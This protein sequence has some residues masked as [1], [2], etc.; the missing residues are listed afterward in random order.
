MFYIILKSRFVSARSKFFKMNLLQ[1][2]AKEKDGFSFGES[3]RYSKDS[4]VAVVPIL[5]KSL[6]RRNYLVLSETK[7]VQIKDTGQINK[8]ELVNNEKKPIYI[9]QGEIFSGKTQ[10]RTAIRSYVVMPG[11]S[12]RIEVRC[13]YASKGINIGETMT[14]GGF[15]TSSFDTTFNRCSYKTRNVEQRDVWKEV[16]V[17]SSNL[18]DRTINYLD[19]TG[20]ILNGTTWNFSDDLKGNIENFSKVI[21]KVLKSVPHFK[22]QVG[23]ATLDLK[24]VSGI[25]CFDLKDSWKAIRENIIKK[26]GEQL[27]KEEK[28]SPF[29]YNKKK[30]KNSIKGV[31]LS[32]FEEKVI[33]KSKDYRVIVLKNDNFIGEMTLLKDNPIHLTL[34]RNK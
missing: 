1:L 26:E 18:S 29:E 28:N 33:F 5:R 15:T 17:N 6:K 9:R 8:V 21:D 4:L 14:T 3:W 7:N 11:E 32:D 34:V 30:A 10:E 25:E 24:G 20:S 19:S 27:V 2:I 23:I 13:I 16:N 12:V 22:N 31:L